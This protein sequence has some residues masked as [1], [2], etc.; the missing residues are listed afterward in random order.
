M[1]KRRGNQKRKIQR[2]WQPWAHNTRHG[3]NTNKTQNH[4][5]ENYIKW[6]TTR[7]SLEIQFSSGERRNPI[8]RFNPATLL[9]ACPK[10]WLWFPAS[11]VVRYYFYIYI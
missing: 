3:T 10:P 9:R 4:N 1:G 11:Y 6:W 2:N 7:T 8:K 5:T